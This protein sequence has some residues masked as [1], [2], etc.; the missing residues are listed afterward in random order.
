MKNTNTIDL[1]Q[2]P[3]LYGDT[4]SILVQLLYVIANVNAM[5]KQ[6]PFYALLP[7]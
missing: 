2:L 5:S 7:T 3:G 4:T 6:E 1:I